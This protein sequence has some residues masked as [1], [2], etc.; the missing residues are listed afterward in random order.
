MVFI[1]DA[2]RIFNGFRTNFKQ[3]REKSRG[4]EPF[5][6]CVAWSFIW[7][8][9][10]EHTH[11]MMSCERKYGQYER[12]PKY[13]ET[14]A[15]SYKNIRKF[16]CIKLVLIRFVVYSPKENEKKQSSIKW[17]KHRHRSIIAIFSSTVN[18]VV[19]MRSY[20]KYRTDGALH[21]C[22]AELI[23]HFLRMF[24]TRCWTTAATPSSPSPTQE[25]NILLFT[26]L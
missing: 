6:L 7:N 18:V 22:S 13:H 9:L 20:L 8:D 10:P 5:I 21:N 12:L 23:Q 26:G 24:G 15:K 2:V 4:Y 1:S 16:F 3:T 19:E 11:K 25:L 14:F 17:M